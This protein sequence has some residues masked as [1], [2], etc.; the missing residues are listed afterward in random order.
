MPYS[1]KHLHTQQSFDRPN[2]LLN[3]FQKDRDWQQSIDPSVEA[4]HKT[5]PDYGETKLHSLPSVASE[6]GFSH[7][8]IKD[9][10][11]RFGL[12]SFKI[13]GASWAVHSTVCEHLRV[14]KSCSR[15]DLRFILR[16]EQDVR[17]V[18]CTEGNWGRACARMAKYLNLPIKIYVPGYMNKYTQDT[19]RAEDADVEVLA[20]GSYDDAIAMAREDAESN[21]SLLVMDTSWD[22]YTEIPKVTSL[23]W[24]PIVV[25]DGL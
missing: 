5:L 20:D 12:P 3:H 25:A 9:E 6:L 17:L 22:G 16:N 11:T 4:F 15:G 21:N 1:V 10:S 23:R 8:F 7:V 18:C 2:I 19:L 24:L 13:L 14:P